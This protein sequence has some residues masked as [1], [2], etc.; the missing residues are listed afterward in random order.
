MQ[1]CSINEPWVSFLHRPSASLGTKRCIFL[2]QEQTVQRLPGWKKT[3]SFMMAPFSLEVFWV[4]LNCWPIHWKRRTFFARK[5]TTEF[6]SWTPRK[7][8]ILVLG[9]DWLQENLACFDYPSMSFLPY[10]ECG[11]HSTAQNSFLR[12]QLSPVHDH[13]YVIKIRRSH[14]SISMIWSM[15]GQSKSKA[16]FISKP[17]QAKLSRIEMKYC[18]SWWQQHHI[19]LTVCP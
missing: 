11:F 8:Y 16:I 1:E 4:W 13:L 7:E 6:S 2:E 5:E 19:A 18:R 17:S 9:V 12:F 15:K 3:S 14:V 10:S